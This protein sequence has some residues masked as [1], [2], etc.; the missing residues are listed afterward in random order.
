[1]MSLN[2]RQP[3]FLAES[4]WKTIPFSRDC[5]PK[6]LLDSLLDILFDTP[7]ILAATEALKESGLDRYVLIQKAFKLAC[8]VRSL[9]YSLERW[10][11]DYIWTYPAIC[12]AENL[13]SLDVLALCELGTGLLPY[14]ARLGEALN[15]YLAA[16]LI[17]ARIAQR[18]SDSSFFVRIA[19][20]PPYSLRDLVSAI[21][22][23]SE[24]HTAANMVDMISMIVT[25]FPLKVA[26]STTEMHEPSLFKR[27]EELLIHLNDYFARKYNIHYSV[28]SGAGAYEV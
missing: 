1:M 18:M 16:H 26:Q 22:L 15:C 12:T 20:R 11:E 7:G 2:D 28:P 5:P 8:W 24:K 19:L 13:K 25:T 4:A 27:V 10:K 3:T 21:V 9:T 6:T 23:V 14:D 17:L